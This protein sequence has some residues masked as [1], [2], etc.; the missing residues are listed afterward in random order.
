MR[1]DEP[2]APRATLDVLLPAAME[3]A[4]RRAGPHLGGAHGVGGVR[5]GQTRRAP[6]EETAGEESDGQPRP[7]AT[8]AN[9]ARVRVDVEIDSHYRL[10]RYSRKAPPT[11][12][13]RS[14]AQERR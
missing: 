12:P 9:F 6:G 13:K 7:D 8:F 5:L 2:V 14:R 4:H 1:I 3:I 10:L 11:S